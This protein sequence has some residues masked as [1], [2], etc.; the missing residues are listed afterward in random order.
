MSIAGLHHVTVTSG[1]PAPNL[2]FY[3]EALGLRLVKRTVNFDD[4]GV[5]HLYFGDAA[6][7]PGTI[8]TTFPFPNARAGQAGAGSTSA[9]AFSV[10][11]PAA[12]VDALERAGTAVARTERF[13]APIWQF[14]DPDGL[15]LELLEGPEGIAG[16]TL[17]LDD[18]EPTARLLVEVFGYTQ[19]PEQQEAGGHRRRLALAGDAPGRFIDL[20]RADASSRSRGGAGTV[21]HIAFRAR[22]RAHQDELA[23]ALRARGEQVTERKDR[24]YFESI[25]FREPGGVLFEIA[26]D[27]PGFAVDE[28]A[29]ALGRELKLPP[30]LEPHRT[31]IEAALPAL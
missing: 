2:A 17:W 26:T 29:D 18:P 30:W 1:P 3:A 31:R 15:A 23:A 19:G 24:Q 25:Y 28:P 7:N 13:G 14:T 9:V 20:W 16:V 21:H 4:P 27:P 10:P 12:R 22:D 11:D 5:Y 6:G 8:M